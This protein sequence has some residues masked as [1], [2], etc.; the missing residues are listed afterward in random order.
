MHQPFLLTV[1]LVLSSLVIAS[2]C[3]KPSIP[4]NID[5]LYSS[6]ASERNQATLDLARCG[7]DAASAVPRLGELLYD[8]NVGVQSGAAYALQRIDTKAA[9]A[10]LEEVERVRAER[11]GR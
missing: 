7:S 1:L 10:I 9:R 11:S 5:R 6:N 2:C 4:Q 8:D 3:D